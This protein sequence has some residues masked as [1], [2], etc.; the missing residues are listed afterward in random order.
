MEISAVPGDVRL[1]GRSDAYRIVE[2]SVLCGWGVKQLGAP[3]G[4]GVQDEMVRVAPDALLGVGNLRP[5]CSLSCLPQLG[6]GVPCSPVAY[7]LWSVL[8]AGRIIIQ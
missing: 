5:L 6:D 8:R 3:S 2:T 7:S 1:Y 4:F